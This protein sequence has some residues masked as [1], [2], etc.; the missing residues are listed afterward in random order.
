MNYLK[1]GL[2][3]SSR[4]DM[5][6]EKA[7]PLTPKS[8]RSRASYGSLSM[9]IQTVKGLCTSGTK[10]FRKQGHPGEHYPPD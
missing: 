9:S 8:E 10:C 7:R 3:T 6:E 2:G 1:G 4:T 5:A